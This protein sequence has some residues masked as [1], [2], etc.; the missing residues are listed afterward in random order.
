MKRY[1]VPLLVLLVLSLGTVVACG[2]ETEAPATPAPE[3]KEP[4]PQPPD[5]EDWEA[6]NRWLGDLYG[7]PPVKNTEQMASAAF[8][9]SGFWF[10]NADK[11]VKKLEQYGIPWERTS[12]FFYLYRYYILHDIQLRNASTPVEF[13]ASDEILANS[14]RDLHNAADELVLM[15]QRGE[16]L[17]I[18][19]TEED[20]V[21]WF[22]END[23]D[24]E[25]L[26]REAIE[27][28]QH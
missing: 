25:R 9:V 27:K 19:A 13:M 11:A 3:Q 8:L 6:L 16:P 23:T 26:A 17:V 18:F 1:V 21:K 5:L 15:K 14:V 22:G 7:L 24:W 12:P 28:G 4:E 20:A 10:E 2:H